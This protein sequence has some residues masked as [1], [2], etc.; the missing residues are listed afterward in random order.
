[1]QMK[2][3]EEKDKYNKKHLSLYDFAL[4][5]VEK[6]MKDYLDDFNNIETCE[7][8]AKPQ[9]LDSI[10]NCI[11]KAQKGQ[12]LALGM[13]EDVDNFQLPQINTIKSKKDL[14]I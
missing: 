4:L 11:S 14:N 10:C 1:M 7:K 6:I 3:N 13:D 9:A 2:P 12:R 8:K 5:L